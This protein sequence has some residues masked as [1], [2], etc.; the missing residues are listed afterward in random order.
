MNEIANCEFFY[1]PLIYTIF[2]IGTEFVQLHRKR[3]WR[4]DG[5]SAAHA[6]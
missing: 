1:W 2:T 5:T 3:I 4:S 6:E